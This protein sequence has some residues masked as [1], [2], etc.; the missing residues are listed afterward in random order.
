MA[1]TFSGRRLRKAR[2][3][4]GLK[5]EH[6]AVAIGRSA[7]TISMYEHGTGYPTVPVLAALADTLDV[8]VDDLFDC[9]EAVSDAA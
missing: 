3:A 8:A 2:L 5:R 4:A 6:L 7:P 1:R 9:S